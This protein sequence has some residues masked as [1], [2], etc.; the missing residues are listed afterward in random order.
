MEIEAKIPL[1]P[2]QLAA[3]RARLGAPDS[4]QH[5]RDI[6]LATAG[7]PV[8]LRVRQEDERAWVTLK[9]GFGEVE[10]IRIRE[11]LEPAIRPEDVP[12]W[13]AIFER[14][15][16]PRGLEVAKTR[17]TY[18]RG[19]VHVLLDEVAGLGSFVEVEALADEAP[20]ALARLEAA[21]A[22]LG[23]GGLPRETRSYRKLL[24]ERQAAR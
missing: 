4:V 22:E 16:L 5:Q 19:D 3:L 20:A 6:Y 11:E 15:G 23:L 13:L 14:L 9:T 1:A 24:Q 10:G 12:T 18:E 17:H 7:L 21:I 8:A 2:E